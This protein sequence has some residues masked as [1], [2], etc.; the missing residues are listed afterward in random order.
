MRVFL[1]LIFGLVGVWRVLGT[2]FDE[3]VSNVDRDLLLS[4]L[5]LM[6]FPAV[7]SRLLSLWYLRLFCRGGRRL[8]FVEH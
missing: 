4:F 8:A 3:L 6:A 1:F 7:L 2:A 5:S